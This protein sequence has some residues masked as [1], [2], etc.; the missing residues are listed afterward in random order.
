MPV[1][2]YIG[3]Q[4]GYEHPV[5]VLHMQAI[6]DELFIQNNAGVYAGPDKWRRVCEGATIGLTTS[7]DGTKLIIP[8]YK[9]GPRG[10]S[11]EEFPGREQFIPTL[12]LGTYDPETQ[13]LTWEDSP[14][15]NISQRNY[16]WN[17]LP[18]L[19]D[20]EAEPIDPGDPW[21]PEFK[22]PVGG[23]RQWGMTLAED[24]SQWAAPAV[25]SRDD[26]IWVIDRSVVVRLDRHQLE[27]TLSAAK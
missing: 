6:G 5:A 1:P 13:Q 26:A 23:D 22:L 21:G 9:G 16:S 25:I 19:H 27:Q 20:F 17:E 7:P 15:P 10:W 11:L 8:R 18:G 2:T 14:A 3:D 12:E 24:G 4:D